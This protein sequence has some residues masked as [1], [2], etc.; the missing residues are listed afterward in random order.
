MIFESVF[1][2]EP[3]SRRVVTGGAIST[4]PSLQRP[5]LQVRQKYPHDSPDT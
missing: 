2:A 4:Y 5:E 3:L 1:H